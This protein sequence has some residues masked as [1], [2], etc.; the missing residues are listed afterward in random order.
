MHYHRTGHKQNAFWAGKRHRWSH[1]PPSY[2]NTEV[3]EDCRPRW[4][5]K[6]NAQS[7]ESS[8][9]PETCV[10]CALVFWKGME[11][12]G[13]FGIIPVHKN[14]DK[15]ECTNYRGIYLLCFHGKMYTTR[16]VKRSHEIIWI[17][18]EDIQ[19]S[20]G[21]DGTTTNKMF[22]VQKF[23]ETSWKC[24]KNVYTWTMDNGRWFIVSY[25]PANKQKHCK[26]PLH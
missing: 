25:D 16:L 12:L 8:S 23:F 2:Q 21:P 19:R 5:S 3:W 18:L 4:N 15:S 20:F 1:R 6:W 9:L 10:S 13:N 24:A 17:N 14:V 11:S 26:K 22:T 7:P